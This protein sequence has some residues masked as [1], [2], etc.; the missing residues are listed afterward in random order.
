MSPL[1]YPLCHTRPIEEDLEE[2]PVEWQ[3][4][5]PLWHGPQCSAIETY[6]YLQQL[7]MPKYPN[8]IDGLMGRKK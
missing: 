4:P 8:M 1:L 2:T 6:Q 3:I 7:A 5:P